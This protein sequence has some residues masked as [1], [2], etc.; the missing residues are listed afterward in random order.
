MICH[1]SETVCVICSACILH[2]KQADNQFSAYSHSIYSSFKSVVIVAVCLFVGKQ[3]NEKGLSPDSSRLVA[4]FLTTFKNVWQMEINS[5]FM[6]PWSLAW[7]VYFHIVATT[8]V[9]LRP[10]AKDLGRKPRLYDYSIMAMLQVDGQQFRLESF[11]LQKT[12]N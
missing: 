3:N 8:A 11:H 9:R 1:W 2:G 12:A 6:Q 4:Q 7:A 10:V 5:L